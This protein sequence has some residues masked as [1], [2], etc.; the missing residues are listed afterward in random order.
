DRL[1]L[2]DFTS[3][4]GER[5]LPTSGS[6]V[7]NPTRDRASQFYATCLALATCTCSSSPGIGH[8]LQGLYNSTSTTDVVA[9]IWSSSELAVL[10]QM[11]V[12]PT[13]PSSPLPP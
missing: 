5:S 7:L 10:S 13:M 2:W 1:F 4:D 11:R 12:P 6:A 3:H 9:F 8:L